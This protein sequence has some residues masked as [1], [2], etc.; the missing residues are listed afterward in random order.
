MALT[1]DE[2]VRSPWLTVWF[3]P[4]QTIERLV[5]TRPAHFVWPLAVLG[6][7][8]SFYSQIS[9]IDGA[10]YSLDWQL[11]LGVVLGGALL[12]FAW[13]YVAGLTL[14]WIGRLLGGQAPALH[15]RTVFAWSGLPTILGLILILAID[16]ANGRSSAAVISPDIV[17]LLVAAFS[18][19]SLVL[20]LMMLGRIEH[21]G[22]WR[23]ILTYALNV[24]LSLAV[25]LFIRSF[26][27]QP[28]D[29]PSGSMKPTLVV[30]DYFFVSK[31]A[32]GYDRFSLPYS[33][34]LPE[35]RIFAFDPAPGDV[36]VFRLPKDTTTDYVKRVVALPGDRVQMKQGALF[37]NDKPVARERLADTGDSQDACGGAAQALVKHWRETLPN[38]VSYETLDC[39]DN[40]FFDNTNV[41]TVPS[42]NFF[43]LGDNRDNSTDSRVPSVG[44][45]PFDH[46]VGRVSLI[47]F[48]RERGAGTAGRIR[49][50]RIGQVVR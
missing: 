48:S 32:Y 10:S 30:G 11:A 13:L 19:W 16:A 8:A 43:V 4:R 41:F 27:Y 37:I 45:I 36:V 46:L 40:A 26:L 50:N 7:V 20:F 28:F 35:G 21:F 34:F 38:G 29:I 24:L 5:A 47:F 17:P 44:F 15:M 31:F 18:S 3:S 1:P 12:G 6:T 14:S 42:G 23:T 22:F 39:L 25:A 2:N 33:R 9:V 49:A